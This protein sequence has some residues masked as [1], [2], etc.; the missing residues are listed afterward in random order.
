MAKALEI[1]FSEME[2]KAKLLSADGI[3]DIGID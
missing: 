3:V 2:N 1:V